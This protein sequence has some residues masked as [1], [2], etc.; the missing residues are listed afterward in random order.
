MSSIV[1]GCPKQSVLT[2]SL[3]TGNARYGPAA[4]AN[5]FIA[6]ATMDA[7]TGQWFVCQHCHQHGGTRASL[8]SPMHPDYMRAL[9]SCDQWA[10]MTL[11][12]LES[13]MTLNLWANGFTHGRLQQHLWDSPILRFTPVD[14][15]TYEVNLDEYMLQLFNINHA[16]NPLYH[17]LA[18]MLQ[19]GCRRY[20][21][22]C[23]DP[24][25][26]GPRTL[27][28]MHR[29]AE[30][31]H[32]AEYVDNIHGNDPTFGVLDS[33]AAMSYHKQD[34]FEVGGSLRR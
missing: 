19:L 34:V 2:C 13:P 3:L 1:N 10:L 20:G 15:R 17:H 11:S 32:T 28:T 26:F 24:S 23:I 7:A 14:A 25:F 29:A 4:V 8:L 12:F 6:Q 5:P 22:P 18:C 30:L 9:V 31:S 33:T 21:H 16:A 27:S